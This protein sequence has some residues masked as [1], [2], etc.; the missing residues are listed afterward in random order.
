MTKSNFIKSVST[1]IAC[2][3]LL[4]SCSSV[5]EKMGMHKCGGKKSEKNSCEAN[6]CSAK[7]GEKHSCK[8][9]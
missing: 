1:G 7:K 8:S 5:M 9:K 6:S 3:A 4:S 2:L